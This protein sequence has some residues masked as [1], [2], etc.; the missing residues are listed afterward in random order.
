MT[1]YQDTDPAALRQLDALYARM[2]PADKLRRVR[3][4][5]LAVN[6][7]ALA[8]RQMRDPELGRA[9]HLRQLAR[10]RL[11]PEAFARIYDAEPEPDGTRRAS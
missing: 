1:A 3:Q 8:G 7:L 2:A 9:E 10:Q 4:L 5:T 11:G 6:R